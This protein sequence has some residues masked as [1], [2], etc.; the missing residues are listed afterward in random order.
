M[1]GGTITK[2]GY[3]RM[4]VGRI[5]GHQIRRFEH[6]LVW[7]SRVGPIPTG[8]EIHHVNEDK[9]DNRFENLELVTRLQHKRL[10][11]GAELRSGEWWKPCS[12]CGAFFPIAHFYRTPDG[13][14]MSRCRPC[15][16]RYAVER[17]KIRRAET[18]LAA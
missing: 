18:R 10:H 17:K 2:A 16:I 6:D 8:F 4:Y 7:E 13:Y 11:A 3:R 5:D 15:L 14:P 9:L 12:R 1:G